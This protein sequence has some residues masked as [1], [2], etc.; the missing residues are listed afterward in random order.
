MI[1]RNQ[2]PANEQA[3][4][5]S[6]EA[7]V[8]HAVDTEAALR[9]S[10]TSRAQG[11][12]D[13][14]AARRRA[15][16][17]DNALP[18]PRRRGP[19]Q[20]FLIQFHN[21]L[22]YVL[23]GAALITALLGHW[24]DSGVIV[25]VVVINALIGFIQEGK[26]E[27]ALDA[28]RQMLSFNAQVLRDGRRRE[29]PAQELVPGD[30]VFLSS[31]DK[32][33]ADL[34]LLETR[35]LRI[36]EAALTGESVASDKS[37]EAVSPAAALGDRSCMAYSS[38]LVIYGQAVG[39]VVGTGAA[40][41]I[42]RISAMLADV[43]ELATP[44]LRQMAIFGRWLT[45]A[46]LILAS[47]AFTFG[48]WVRDYSTGDM[49]LVA[50]G[51]AVALIP[52]GLPAIITITLA[53]GVRRM[54]RRNAIIR[55]LPAVEA[56]G[57]VTIICTDK[58]GTLTRN[59][60]TVR[61]AITADMMFEVSGT[62][63]DPHGGFATAAGEIDTSAHPVLREI[64]LV[65]LLCNDAALRE[66]G[67]EWQLTGDPTEGALISL[68]MKAGLDEGFEREALPRI[69]VIP[70]ESEHR[71]M[72]TLHHD[73]DGR[74]YVFIKGAPE[75]ILGLCRW[76]REGGRDAPLDLAYWSGQ[77]DT[78]AAQGMRL[79][80]VAVRPE[81]GDIGALDFDA[82]K[83]GRFTLLAVLGLSDPPREEAIAAVARCRAAGIRV[84][85]VTGDHAA[86][87]RA[88]GERLGMAARIATL[89]GPEIDEMDDARLATLVMGTD[90]F[91]R[92][93]PEHKLR[94]VRAL[95]SH[96]E[97]VAMTGD[98]VNDAP[99]LKRADVGIAMGH[100]GTEV[101]KEAAEM[102]LADDNF[103]SITAAVEE[104]RAV[105]DNIRKA[106]VF[107][108]PTNGGEA[109]MLL[110]AILF[111]LTMPISPVQILWV[112][113][114]TALTLS[115]AI[116]FETRESDTMTRPPRNPR[117]PLLTGF[118]IWRIT[119][120]TILMVAGGIGLFLWESGQGAGL[121]AARTATVN[122]LVIGEIAYL[123][124]VRRFTA[125]A[126]NWQGI[127]GNHYALLA[128]GLLLAFQAAFTYL[129][130]MQSLFG[131]A[132]IDAKAWIR[133]LLFGAAVFLIV[134]LEKWLL[135]RLNFL[136]G[137]NRSK[138]L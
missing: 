89:S 122:A 124:N 93:S 1:A 28:I 74:R 79:L 23:M 129:P 38:T 12:S 39:V 58:T 37:V 26:A 134:E 91:A 98:G 71:F 6:P 132:D 50:V 54:A 123:F 77:I 84:K 51:L 73:H 100:K 29:I 44:L 136:K 18:S 43:Q 9:F 56:L 3:M 101:A 35:S 88:I 34:R 130:A 63:Y 76:Q 117:A 65:A 107:I 105:Y 14:E 57:S 10:E 7:H 118:L 32:V 62:G 42:G 110:T 61:R 4:P 108:L 11:I 21:I 33:P 126:F 104:G 48:A 59:E 138:P 19:L 82:V 41:E 81:T 49:F 112:N 67:G 27:R 2:V 94:L 113:M 13:A 85:M 20:R 103:A 52:E 131:T 111:G 46:T 36:E 127:L 47:F 66:S 5:S 25:G 72:A 114:I 24:V 121:E 53:I 40:T 119:F 55:R 115:L 30:I 102:V 17:G 120:V 99:A 128:V 75:N 133:I 106:I 86:T 69:D 116:A 137:K 135:F 125:S 96:G 92:A 83:A 78:A 97:V 109:G 15:R 45:W 87:A 90:I 31:G 80:A 68:A 22:I 60:M 8:W 70:F 95:Q 16:Y 64:G